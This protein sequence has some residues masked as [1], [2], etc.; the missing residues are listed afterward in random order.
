MYVCVCRA[1]T[2]RQLCQAIAEG[3]GDLRGLRERLGL[4]SA[5]GRCLPEARRLLKQAQRRPSALDLDALPPVR[6]AA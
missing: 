4:G 2:D 6:S 1:V 3:A 5:C